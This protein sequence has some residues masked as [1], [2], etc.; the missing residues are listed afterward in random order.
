MPSN[1]SHE[2]RSSAAIYSQL[3]EMVV[4]Y[5]FSPSQQLQPWSLADAF[6]VSATPVREALIRLNAEGLV[7][8]HPNKGFFMKP[9]NVSENCELYMLRSQL[10]KCSVE[11]IIEHAKTATLNRLTEG[12]LFHLDAIREGGASALS[13]LEL[14]FEDCLRA[15]GSGACFEVVRGV[16]EKTR[17]LRSLFIEQESQ[18]AVYIEILEALVHAV[19]ERNKQAAAAKLHDELELK[20]KCVPGLCDAGLIR[21]FRCQ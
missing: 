6:K 20:L 21:A 9:L 16:H 5:A 8:T 4:S 18:A 7:L 1:A 14:F 13:S 17:Y 19:R 15:A 10:V 3:K 12:W 11:H 2:S